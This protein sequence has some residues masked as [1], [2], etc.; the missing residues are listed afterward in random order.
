MP[1]IIRVITTEPSPWFVDGDYDVDEFRRL[2]SVTDPARVPHAI[3]V[4]RNLPIYDGAA[5]GEINRHPARRR[6]LLGELAWVLGD[7][8]GAFAIKGGLD[9][10]HNRLDDATDI[11][12]AII[13]EQH[14]AGRAGRRPLRHARFQRPRVELPREARRR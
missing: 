7:G 1:T 11:F 9:Q 6:V 2:P 13:A 3:A 12:Q 10:Q 5:L 4:E 14:A 8:P